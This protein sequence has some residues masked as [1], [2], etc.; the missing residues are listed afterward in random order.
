LQV[1]ISKDCGASF[2]ATGSLRYSSDSLDLVTA[3]NSSVFFIPSS[4]LDWKNVSFSI[5]G[6][7]LGPG[8]RM[9]FVF[10]TGLYPNN[11]YIDNV[12]INGTLLVDDTNSDF[13]GAN[14]F[15][16]PTEGSTTLS[17]FISGSTKIDITLTDMSGRI[18]ERWSPNN[19][20]PGKQVLEIG[21]DELA[22]GLYMVNMKSD[23]NSSTMKLI[24][25]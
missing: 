19:N 7:F 24:V 10:R 14:L 15:P 5:P 20:T 16:N 1:Y 13:Y 8:F 22:K 6:S 23:R 12:N 2:N 25:R 9:K 4:S 11:F 21:T 17:Y 3:G 18:V